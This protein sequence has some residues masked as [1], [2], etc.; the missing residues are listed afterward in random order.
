[1][2]KESQTGLSSPEAQDEKV[3]WSGAGAA[4]CRADADRPLSPLRH[5]TQR[6]GFVLPAASALEVAP[7]NFS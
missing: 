5:A 6:A 3:D 7:N 2:R 4:G 1:M